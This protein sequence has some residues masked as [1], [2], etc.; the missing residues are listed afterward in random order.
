MNIN[1]PDFLSGVSR[2]W[3][4]LSVEW[5]KILIITWLAASVMTAETLIRIRRN[6]EK[7]GNH[8]ARLTA[9]D[10]VLLVFLAVTI[11]W[12][13][14]LLLAKS[15]FFDPL[16]I[17]ELEPFR[18]I[19]PCG[20][21]ILLVRLGILLGL[22]ALWAWARHPARKSARLKP[23]DVWQAAE[24]DDW[25][26][27]EAVLGDDKSHYGCIIAELT[28]KII[29]KIPV[30][31]GIMSK[32]EG[33][34][35]TTTDPDEYSHAMKRHGQAEDRLK[36]IRL[37]LTSIRGTPE[38]KASLLHEFWNDGKCSSLKAV[39]PYTAIGKKI[40]I[41]K[42]ITLAASLMLSLTLLF[43]VV[44]FYMIEGGSGGSLLLLLL[45]TLPGAL[46][47]CFGLSFGLA[48]LVGTKLSDLYEKRALANVGVMTLPK[49]DGTAIRNAAVA[50]AIGAVTGAMIEHSARKQPIS[51]MFD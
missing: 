6:T 40:K 21:E 34:M 15:M 46:A 27:V 20:H 11:L 50:A 33:I 29:G 45:L 51:E 30:Y 32:Y 49:D 19:R 48:T 12:G 1:N 28:R 8:D 3:L 18:H 25:D 38:Q 42:E 7:N 23:S 9:R 14:V 5:N 22:G 44:F 26:R 24:A 2:I 10:I 17:L 39:L 4:L 47:V 43:I 37:A 13:P 35:K 41:H 31:E 36:A 16:K